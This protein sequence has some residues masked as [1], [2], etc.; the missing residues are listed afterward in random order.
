LNRTL[1]LII[2]HLSQVPAEGASSS[3]IAHS[4]KLT[5]AGSSDVLRFGEMQDCIRSLEQQLKSLKGRVD[6]AASKTQLAMD[7]EKFLLEELDIMS[8]HL[9]CKCFAS[10]FLIR[11]EIIFVS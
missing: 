3:S 10:H 1:V 7:G 5:Q 8:R 6:V 11:L 2:V 9:E 4:L